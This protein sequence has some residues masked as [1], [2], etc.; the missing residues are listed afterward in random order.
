MFHAGCMFFL[1]IR[2]HFMCWQPFWG[3]TT[4][5]VQEKLPQVHPFYGSTPILGQWTAIM[6]RQ[7]VLE[8]AWFIY[9][10]EFFW[11]IVLK[12]WQDG[13]LGS[14]IQLRLYSEHVGLGSWIPN[15]LFWSNW[16]YYLNM[17]STWFERDMEACWALGFRFPISTAYPTK[18]WLPRIKASRL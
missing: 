2:A 9:S 17:I 11:P 15:K 10:S 8:F 4:R 14:L 18:L 5:S 13:V 6:C 16:F 1:A 12:P 3:P 7:I